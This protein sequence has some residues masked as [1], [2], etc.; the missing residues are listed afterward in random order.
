MKTQ[1]GAR[2]RVV[3]LSLLA[4]ALLSACGGG[5]PLDG[6]WLGTMGTNRDVNAIVLDDGNYYMLYSRPGN[7]AA[8]G[9]L[10][11]GSGDFMAGK[12]TSPDA[13]D[14]NWEGTGTQLA[15]VSAKIKLTPKPA[16]T[17][18]VNTTAFSIRP[19]EMFD[20][21][22]QLS[23][24][25]GA[26]T[27]NVVFALGVRP[28]TFTVTATGQ[29]STTINGCAITGQVVPRKYS[30]AYNLTMT[31]G[32]YPCVFPN[33]QFTGVAFYREDLRQLQAAVVHG[34]RTQAIAFS[35][36]KQ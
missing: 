13:R 20:R 8:I 35:G 22:A 26:H 9:G 11:Q 3:S 33:A 25:V 10:V 14:F 15:T 12:F 30:N 1:L 24:I 28:A 19:K 34:S 32:G 21:D 17:G 23:D 36:I 5:D 29:V 7:P 27:G 18:T 2:G 6:L 4:G 31:F 16:V